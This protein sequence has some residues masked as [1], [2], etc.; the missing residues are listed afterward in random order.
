MKL[1]L[2][3]EKKNLLNYYKIN[4]TNKKQKQPKKAL[5]KDGADV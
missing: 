4:S 5:L 1:S 3:I 2:T